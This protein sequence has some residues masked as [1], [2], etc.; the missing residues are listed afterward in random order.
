MDRP[1]NMYKK[2]SPRQVVALK[3]IISLAFAADSPL[4]LLK[5]LHHTAALTGNAK[6]QEEDEPLEGT[7]S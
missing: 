4:N 7:E 3:H 1:W 6:C 5:C 2:G